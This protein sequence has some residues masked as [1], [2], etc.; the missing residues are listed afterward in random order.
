MAWNAEFPDD[1]DVQWSTELAGDLEGNRNAPTRQAQDDDVATVI[2][3]VEPAGQL[4]PGVGA[5]FKRHELGRRFE[6]KKALSQFATHVPTPLS[7][8]NTLETGLPGA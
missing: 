2:V 6:V 8:S 3:S 5:I 7:Q 4:A 1:E